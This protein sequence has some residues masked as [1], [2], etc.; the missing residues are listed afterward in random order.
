[1][2]R[3]IPCERTGCDNRAAYQVVT[4]TDTRFTCRADVG[5]SLASNWV[6]VHAIPDGP[7]GLTRL[8]V[9]AVSATTRHE[10]G[11]WRGSRTPTPSC[12]REPCVG[13]GHIQPQ[14]RVR[15]L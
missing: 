1:M 13:T 7:A 14:P 15:V 10:S 6:A 5:S 11:W 4:A 2:T 3:H 12:D 9:I 8:S